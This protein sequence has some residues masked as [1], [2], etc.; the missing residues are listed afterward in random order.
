MSQQVNSKESSTISALRFI[1]DVM[2]SD[3]IPYTT[4]YAKDGFKITI[5][6]NESTVKVIKGNLKA[7]YPLS[8]V[9][10]IIFSNTDG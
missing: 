2:F 8:V 9:E 7:V 4:L 5:S 1:K 3:Y 6:S 10:A